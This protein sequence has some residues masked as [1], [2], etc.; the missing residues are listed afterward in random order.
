[1]ELW[2]QLLFKPIVVPNISSAD[3]SRALLDSLSNKNLGEITSAITRCF[4]FLLVSD[5]TRT[6]PVS[7]QQGHCDQKG[8]I[9]WNNDVALVILSRQRNKSSQC[10]WLNL[11]KSFMSNAKDWNT[12]FVIYLSYLTFMVQLHLCVRLPEWLP[13]TPFENIINGKH[14]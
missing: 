8:K 5:W 7:D 12:V 9:K 11:M 2:C 4:V 13:W 3:G 6:I 10:F 1:M 14:F